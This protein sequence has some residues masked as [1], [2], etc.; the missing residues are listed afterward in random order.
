[1]K[2]L[3]VAKT[4][5]GSGACIGGIT[6][7]GQSVRLI[8]ADA[9]TNEHVGLEYN[10]GDVWEVEA[11]VPQ[12]VVPPHV[13]NIVVQSKRRMGPM[14]I[15][16]RF[17]ERHM[18]PCI[19]G[20]EQLYDGLVQA[21]SSGVLHIA[22]RSGVPPYSTLFWRPDQPL[23]RV[24]DSKRLRYRYP[25]PDGGRTLTFV[26]F[27]EPIEVIPAGAL[28]RV[29]LAHWWRPDDQPDAELRCHV[30]LSGYFLAPSR[31][32]QRSA[33]ASSDTAAERPF[34][35]P[36]GDMPA[37]R[38]FG[39]PQ[40][41]G[42]ARNW[43]E[44]QGF[45]P[46]PLSSPSPSPHALLKSVFGYDTFWPLQGEIIDNVLARRDTLAVMPTGGGKS[47][48][49]QLPALLF[50]GLTLV[51]SPLIALMQDQVDQLRALGAPA[52][53]LN[54]TLDYRSYVETMSA[55]R[56]GQVKLLYTSPE[57][58]L[59]P[60]TL[61][62]LDQSRLDC[63]T[64][65]EAHCISQWGHDF[66]PEYRQLLPVRQ[67]YPQAVCLAFTATATERVRQDIAS[68]LGFTAANTFVASFNRPNLQLASRSRTDGLGQVLGFLDAHREQSGIIYCST[69]ETVDNLA[70]QLAGAGWPALPYHAG[71]DDATRQ[72][73]QR[74]FV[75]ADV[76][77]MVA[78]IAFGMGINKP[79]VR[80]VV[81][82]NLP[83]DIESYYQEIG[84][85]GRDGLP[86]DCLLLYSQKD[87]ATILYFVEEGAPSQQ[88]GATAR[89]Q[90]MLRYA[91]AGGCRRT[92]LLAYFGERFEG[93][94]CGACDNCQREQAGGE[95][96][97]LTAAAVKFLGCVKDTGQ[98]FGVSHIANVLRGSQA[99]KVLQRRHDRLSVHG[100]GREHS[101]RQWSRFGQQFIAEG[102]LEQDME[103]GGLRLT[104]AGREVLAGQ[105]RVL[106]AAPELPAEAP[107]APPPYDAE[108][109]Q[110]LRE[111]RRELADAANVPP[112]VVFSDRT[113][114]EMATYY[115][116]TPQRLLDMA[117]VGQVKLGQYGGAFLAVLRDYCA[118]HDLPE[119][120]KA[121]HAPPALTGGQA[122]R[123]F[124]EVGELFAAGYSVA[125]LQ[126]QYGVERSTI[127]GH[128]ARFHQ[129]GGAVDGER[130]L[131]ASRL[132]AEQQAQ[133]LALFD[134]LG[135]EALSPV[136]QALN[137]SISYEELHVMRV[138]YMSRS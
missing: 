13:E 111:L 28:V 41:D 72:R 23:T 90:A 19:G 126:A 3:I 117:G 137:G 12:Q 2:V 119:R 108:L 125:Q 65:D 54:S 118:A 106:L 53:F 68:Q 76:A 116:Q 135:A 122:K 55:V 99:K 20:P 89:L 127:L 9:A 73:N 42:H 24:Q 84:R 104:A 8:A 92:P 46:V 77:I 49:Y 83:R 78:T 105:R 85:A 27:Q 64:I 58:L 132:T 101:D 57:T 93:E 37:E 7:E 40:G 56:A 102:L 114:V 79:N 29:S 1:M 18:P 123:R 115:P 61:V 48:C 129:Q 39:S 43:G 26:G 10:V 38:P 124:V 66:R 67:R 14:S 25:T 45:P 109:F 96:I 113:L 69:R 82:F 59:R 80:F 34:G 11:A 62:L 81:H 30:Q 17:I 31:V 112:F 50:D 21:T 94:P 70:A 110:V 22:E 107:T 75:R 130:V 74:Q 87:V 103:H 95:K 86:A 35:R 51:I 4:R 47:L 71:L 52:A 98:I 15:P 136:F 88:A 120:P 36:Q 131:A 63:L 60:E 33:Q 121:P 91:Q 128:L 100:S 134:D 5:Q 97:D 6:F 16:E 32:M 133:V 138:A 44:T